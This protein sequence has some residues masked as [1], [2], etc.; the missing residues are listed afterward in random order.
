[1][2][3]SGDSKVVRLYPGEDPVPGD[4][5]H[6][7]IER[8]YKN[9]G[10]KEQKK[11]PLFS[12]ISAMEFLRRYRSGGTVK[13]RVVPQFGDYEY[14]TNGQ[15]VRLTD[16]SGGSELVIS[17]LLNE[18]ERKQ[19]PV[20][21][22]FREGETT[23]YDYT[24]TYDNDDPN[25]NYKEGDF[26][27]QDADLAKVR[28]IWTDDISYQSTWIATIRF[29]DSNTTIENCAFVMKFTRSRNDYKKLAGMTCG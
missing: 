21:N 18:T 13:Y 24:A 22:G 27:F 2:V 4:S 3:G 5:E 10:T 6:S 7:N 11:Y 19:L 23:R 12:L 8:Q 20:Y 26:K 17:P 9:F 1:M 16:A 14:G 25:G 28:F 15:Y 29:Y